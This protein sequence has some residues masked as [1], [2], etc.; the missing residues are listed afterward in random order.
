MRPPFGDPPCRPDK[1]VLSDCLISRVSVEKGRT[2]LFTG[3]LPKFSD[4][5]A[6]F[7]VLR[8]AVLS[9]FNQSAPDSWAAARNRGERGCAQ[10]RRV[11]Q[12]LSNWSTVG[13]GILASRHLG[14]RME[15]ISG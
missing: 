5:V 6:F 7:M 13:V 8:L 15:T 3:L 12:T 11:R 14:S 1:G 2:G 9:S 10:V 4:K